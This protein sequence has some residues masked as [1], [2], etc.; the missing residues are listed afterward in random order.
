[1]EEGDRVSDRGKENENRNMRKR[2]RIGGREK[3]RVSERE[4]KNVR[5][6]R[7]DFSKDLRAQ[8]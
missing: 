2:M 6:V 8:T 3:A 5:L 7:K 1:M 4:E